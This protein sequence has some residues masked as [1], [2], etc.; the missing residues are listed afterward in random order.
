[1]NPFDLNGPQFLLFYGALGLVS[2]VFLRVYVTLRERQ[3]PIPNLKMSDPFLIAFLRG[4]KNETIRIASMSLID[5]G[6]LEI[7]SGSWFS[8]PTLATAQPSNIN[9]GKSRIERAL[10]RLFIAR[11]EAGAAFTNED[12]KRA[13]D[14][15]RNELG[16]YRLVR[17]AEIV[18]ERLVPVGVIAVLLLGVSG[19]KIAVALDRGRFNI[20]FLIALTVVIM[21][22]LGRLVWRH[23]TGLGDLVLSRSEE[24]T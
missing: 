19:I 20:E 11:Q 22:L 3:H 14:S 17:T 9:L 13:C 4:S 10:L 16:E 23:R 21:Y 12:C 15:Y 2:Y 5:R 8:T 6:L 7:I 24:H 18:V 1:M